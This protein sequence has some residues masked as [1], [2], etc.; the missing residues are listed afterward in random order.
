M[1]NELTL[2]EVLKTAIAKEITAQQLYA[3]LAKRVTNQIARETFQDIVRQERGHQ[4]LLER[5]Q[6]GELK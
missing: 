3:D 4:L 5:Y 6:R 1:A 2:E